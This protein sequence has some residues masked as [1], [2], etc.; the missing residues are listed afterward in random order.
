MDS[1]T[2]CLQHLVDWDNE[3]AAQR[4][5]RKQRAGNFPA[6]STAPISI[7]VPSDVPNSAWKLVCFCLNSIGNDDDVAVDAEEVIRVARIELVKAHVES[8]LW[9]RDHLA[10]M[11]S[12]GYEAEAEALRIRLSPELDSMEWQDADAMARAPWRMA[13]FDRSAADVLYE[14]TQDASAKQSN[15]TDEQLLLGIALSWVLEAVCAP[16]RA[17][18]LNL[19]SEAGLA[20]NLA[21]YS[22]GSESEKADRRRALSSAGEK[23]AAAR[24]HGSAALKSWALE[25]AGKMSGADIDIARKLSMKVPAHLTESSK[26]PFRLIY[27][28]LRTQRVRK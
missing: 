28:A 26:Y 21:G 27:D 1:E 12:K 8:A 3:S 17:A 22:F 19:M 2:H 5:K 10:E 6:A 9:W 20:I 23:G 4:T 24:H 14:R 7:E 15:F 18:M 13:D 16:D 25:E 11:L